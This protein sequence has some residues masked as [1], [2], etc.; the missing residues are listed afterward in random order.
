MKALLQTISHSI[1]EGKLKCS[2]LAW[3]IGGSV[4][5]LEIFLVLRCLPSNIYS[6]FLPNP[7][8]LV[9]HNRFIL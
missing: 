6:F 7:F 1:H 4:P 8:L 5:S 9:I 2:N 3:L